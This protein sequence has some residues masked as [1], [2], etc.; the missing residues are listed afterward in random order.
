MKMITQEMVDRSMETAVA[1]GYLEEMLGNTEQVT[2]D[3]CDHDVDFEG[4]FSE[5]LVGQ[6]ADWQKRKREAMEY[7]RF[8]KELVERCLLR[9]EFVLRSGQTSKIYFDKYRFMADPMVMY[10][11]VKLLV[12]N[13]PVECDV[14]AGLETGGI[15]LATAIQQSSGGASSFPVCF[16]R[17]QPKT[18][19]T[20]RQVEGADVNGKRVV[21]IED[22][23]TTGGAVFEAVRALRDAGAIVQDVLCVIDR[24]AVYVTE[25]GSESV[26]RA[27]AA[28]LEHKLYLT[29]LFTMKD[30]EPFMAAEVVAAESTKP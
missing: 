7:P 17:K 12:L 25:D 24:S 6:V 27:R 13:L 16:V 15:P 29:S 19:G 10:N 3:L 28:F 21:V 22:V 9:G 20:A 26:T 1:N 4:Q 18:Y 23:V 30:L 11:V 5:V 14:L 2:I 8:A